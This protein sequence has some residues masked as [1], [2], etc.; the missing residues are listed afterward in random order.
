L[1]LL[2]T[3]IANHERGREV[4]QAAISALEPDGD[5]R[6]LALALLALGLALIGTGEIAGARAALRRGEA[7]ARAADDAVSL[8][9]IVIG[10]T[11]ITIWADHDYVT[12]LTLLEELEQLGQRT[13]DAQAVA[14]A[15]FCL[16]WVAYTQSE[17]V[18]ARRH[19]E[20]ARRLFDELSDR[21]FANVASSGLADIGRRL[22]HLAEAEQQYQDVMATWHTLGHRPGVVRCLECLGFIARAQG[23]LVQAATLLGAA[24]ALREQLPATMA[25]DEQAEYAQ[26]LALLQQ[27]FEPRAPAFCTEW[28]AGR[29]LSYEAALELAL[30]GPSSAMEAGPD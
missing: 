3:N 2:C 9:L 15:W 16:G 4:A 14:I 10:L 30:N 25:P 18:E 7:L 1:A 12:A 24:E 5:P 23:R 13:G 28:Q 29:R 27:Q 22:G 21:S 6:E 26:E 19:Y 20:K 11:Q 17:W 8:A